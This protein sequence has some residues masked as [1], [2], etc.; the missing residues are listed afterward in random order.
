MTSNTVDDDEFMAA[1][2]D[3]AST[4]LNDQKTAIKVENIQEES[5]EFGF[6]NPDFQA[7]LKE[8]LGDENASKEAL[9]GMEQ[10]LKSLEKVMKDGNIDMDDGLFEKSMSDVFN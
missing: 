6:E 4:L 10:M 9:Q 1:V 7:K 5:S 3:C 8:V 2:D